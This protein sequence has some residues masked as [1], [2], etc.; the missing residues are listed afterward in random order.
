[1]G[2]LLRSVSGVRW[3]ELRDATGAAAGGIPSLLS[4][5][6]Y[7]DEDTARI[8]V[9]DLGDAICA[10]GFVVGEA[11]APT[12]P[13]LLELA[14]SAHVACGAELLDLLGDS[15]KDSRVR[16]P[17]SHRGCRLLRTAGGGD[18]CSKVAAGDGRHPPFPGAMSSHCGTA[19][20][21]DSRRINTF[22]STVVEDFTL[23]VEN[24]QVGLAARQN[25][26]DTLKKILLD[27]GRPH[28]PQRR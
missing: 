8:A 2:S 23:S 12:V 5:I 1:M 14:G 3:G 22:S 19:L 10:L 16:R 13:F 9:D 20:S 6:A 26:Y 11:T 15:R 17:V 4:R 24:R 21:L 7:G 25:A 18:T 27:A 28:G